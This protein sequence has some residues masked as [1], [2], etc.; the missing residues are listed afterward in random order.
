MT[1]TPRCLNRPQPPN[2][3]AAHRSLPLMIGS[4]AASWQSAE[5]TRFVEDAM[6]NDEF[7]WGDKES[8]VVKSQDA[9]AVYANPDGDIVIRRQ[10]SWQD[11]EDVWIVVSRGQV[12]RVIEALEKVLRETTE[13]RESK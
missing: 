1:I 3:V 9:I 11:N 10:Q 5:I 12:R 7:D 13:D 2:I 8:V 6:A 4:G